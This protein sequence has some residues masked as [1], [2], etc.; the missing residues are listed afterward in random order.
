[1]VVWNFDLYTQKYQEPIA[2]LGNRSH[3]IDLHSRTD[4]VSQV[5]RQPPV[6]A[7]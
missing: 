7:C 2:A 3:W 1:M 5:F 4:G 6:V